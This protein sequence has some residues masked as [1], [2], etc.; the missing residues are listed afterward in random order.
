MMKLGRLVLA[1][2]FLFAVPSIASA[3]RGGKKHKH[4][5]AKK[6]LK[7]FDKAIARMDKDGDGRL[8]PDEVDEKVMKRLARFDADGDGWVTREEII[9]VL[10]DRQKARKAQK[11]QRRQLREP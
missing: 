5:H 4:K 9:V 2:L 6:I 11:A 3:D 7:K 8:G 1:S 10:K